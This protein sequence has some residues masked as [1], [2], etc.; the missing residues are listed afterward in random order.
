M[1]TLKENIQQLFGLVLIGHVITAPFVCIS[2]SL[3]L[4]SM[5]MFWCSGILPV[6]VPLGIYMIYF[7]VPHWVIYLF[8]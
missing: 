4:D 1:E 2:V 7:D 3:E 6:S 5:F 8:G